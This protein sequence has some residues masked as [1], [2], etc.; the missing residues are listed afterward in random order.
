MPTAVERKSDASSGMTMNIN[1]SQQTIPIL[2]FGFEVQSPR[3]P[4]S[5]LPTGKRQWKPVVVTKSV[6]NASPKLYSMACTNEVLNEVT[7]EFVDDW[8]TFTN[9][10]LVNISPKTIAGKSVQA[11]TFVFE[12]VET[13]R[14]TAGRHVLS[15]SELTWLAFIYQ[16]VTVSSGGGT[17]FKDSWATPC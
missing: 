2:S 8:L 9:A 12:D 11:L 3:D 10:Q 13:G 14:G 6:D 5:G 16:K 4:Q 1:G 17:T 7:F 15:D